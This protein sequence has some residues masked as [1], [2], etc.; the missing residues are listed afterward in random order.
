[1]RSSDFS[2]PILLAAILLVL[3]GHSAPSRAQGLPFASLNG[4]ELLTTFQLDFLGASLSSERAGENVDHLRGDVFIPVSQ[5]ET[6]AYALQVRGSRL[7]LDKDH[8]TGPARVPRDLGS[9]SVGPFFRLKLDSGDF[10]AG[11][12]QLGRAGSTFRSDETATTLSANIFWARKK[13]EGDGQWVYLL[14]YSN[15]RSTLNNVPLPGFAYVKGF[16]TEATQGFWAAG[17]PFFFV[18]LR[19]Q[20]WS[21]STLLTPFTSFI[22]GG[23]SFLGPF[24]M[25]ARFGWAPQGFKVNGGPAERILY[26][27]FRTQLGVRGP[28]AKWAMLSLGVAY[29]D[30]RRV[31]WGESL[32]KVNSAY[33]SRLEDEVSLFFNIAG[34][35]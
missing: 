4:E 17:A 16:K 8:M 23:Y 35:F 6:Q 1:M 30:G 9:I 14:N 10:V 20:P 26:E 5:G 24:G 31:A 27:E 25:F 28:I 11:D 7:T 33:E 34:R 2:I 13:D 22:E 21:F 18:M 15:S 12:V 29:S 19:S 3:L 32:T